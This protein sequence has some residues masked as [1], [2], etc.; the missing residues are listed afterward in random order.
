MISHDKK[1]EKSRKGTFRAVSFENMLPKLAGDG[2]GRITF[3]FSGNQYY[4]LLTA[5]KYEL[6]GIVMQASIKERDIAKLE[7][8]RR[9]MEDA[10]ASGDENK[11]K[12]T[13]LFYNQYAE[14]F[15]KQYGDI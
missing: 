7:M 4:T 11:I 8:L 1:T 9:Q 12:I 10:I 14:Y 3:V 2:I 15:K 13:T 6:G 5:S